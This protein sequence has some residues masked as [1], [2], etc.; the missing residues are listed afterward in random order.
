MRFEIVVAKHPARA[1]GHS[2]SPSPP[3]STGGS[4][5]LARG[6]ARRAARDVL[7]AFLDAA[8]GREGVRE[9]H[10]SFVLR[11]LALALVGLSASPR[12]KASVR[13]FDVP[14]ELAIERFGA[15][16]CLSVYRA[17]PE[18]L[19]AIY[20]RAVPFDEI[21]TAASDVFDGFIGDGS[22]H[23]RAREELGSAVAQLRALGPAGHGG[24]VAVPLP[25]AVSVEP[26]RDSPL[27]FGVEF[28]IR[29]GIVSRLVSRGAEPDAESSA[30]RLDAVERSDLHALL[31][32]GRMRAE[33][34]GRA[35]DLGEC[36]PVLVAERLVDLGRRAFDAWE[37]GLP[38][39]AR[40]VAGGVTVGVRVRSD[41]ELALTLGAA[42][43]SARH[44]VHTFPALGVVDV[45]EATLG[46]GRAL[47]RA[48]LR[49]DRSQSANLR[50]SA[51][52]RALREASE[53]LSHASQT[54]AKINP[55]PEP[56]R[57]FAAFAALEETR[58]V[59]PPKSPASRLSYAPRWRAIIPGIDLRSTYLCG[60][61]VV[62][63]AAS[64]MWALDRASGRVLWRTDVP[65]GTSFVTPGGI[66]R[67]ATDG[68]LL[69]FDFATG[70][71]ALRTRI[72]PRVGGGV[73]GAVVHLPGLPRLVIVTEG[74]H[75]LVAIDLATG[76]PRWRWSWGATRGPTR[77]APRIKRA[78]RL[79][80]FT[81]GDGALT[82]LDVMMGAVVW[83]VR[84]RLRFRTPPTVVRDALFVVSGG[85]H[86]VARLYCIDPYAGHV[87]W[88]TGLADPSAPCTVQ[89]APIVAGGAVAV[90]IRRKQGL[91]LAAFRLDDGS[92]LAPAHRTDG[93]LGP[94]AAVG[95]SW[96][97]VDD[98]FI[99][100]APTGEI[101][102]VDATSGELRWR[103]VLGPRPLEADVPRRL[104]PVL[105]C[106]A[107]F[108]PCSLVSHG[109]RG[110]PA[111]KETETVNGRHAAAGVCI[112]RPS[113]GAL[114]GSIAPA[115]AIPDL[116]RVDERCDV[117]V[118]EE[119]GHLAA[120][121]ARS[122]LS[123][124]V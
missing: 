97:A 104:E 124:V 57:A 4:D 18:P 31:F 30:A 78:G 47:V 27:S 49:R 118:A 39:H 86:G 108:V 7:D 17:G 77:G 110:A 74:D 84:D 24:D 23:V 113:D 20:D 62:V 37:R 85:A 91:A 88:A 123:I 56:Y 42:P 14:W 117:Y 115:G 65:R 29:E 116:L 19:V 8:F 33:I 82:A 32:R 112:L 41:G 53:A 119:S 64:E 25:T 34:H 45:L 107:L 50:L 95:T 44:A 35:I 48:I 103:H 6:E 90:P 11:D 71:C 98:A 96:L 121:G 120:F 68:A 58:Q 63:G 12:A 105:R 92:A 81:S 111:P 101:V 87:R 43:G 26:D 13:F 94:D 102:A 9:M 1:V 60:D 5:L 106:G 61:R 15:T 52:R 67:L 38:F 70:E 75:H 114:I 109:T 21:V 51:F 59:G 54:D 93:A 28:A 16:A 10:A 83:R 73:A 69:V 46:F 76:E 55:T 2:R 100:N 22:T 89:G 36:H 40:V 99:G 66:A 122:R 3:G 79:L 80:Y 72:A